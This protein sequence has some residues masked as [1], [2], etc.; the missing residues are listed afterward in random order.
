MRLRVEQLSYRYSDQAVIDD[1]SIHVAAGEFVGVVGPNGSGKSTLLKNLYRALKPDTGKILLDGE[2]YDMLNAKKI[3][4]KIGVV[5]QEHMIPFDF[6]VDEI[7][8]MGRS[9]YKKLFDM[10]TKEDRKIVE[11]A[12]QNVGLT[13]LAKTNY[14]NLSGGERQRVVI[15]RVLAQQTNFLML[16]EPTNHLDIQYQLQMFD[17]IK[18]LK[19]TV[20]SAIHDLNLAALYCDRIYI[21]KEG[22]IYTSGTPEEVLTPQLLSE[23]FGI[24]A[25]III[26]PLT[27]KVNI[28]YLPASIE[29]E[30][31]RV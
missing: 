31:E 24:R 6:N 11:Q 21:M 18:G 9:P 3:A 4:Q 2:D 7:V 12:L 17:L 28:T 16:D 10:D 26:H 8:A 23:V 30:G 20:V 25:H 5:G 22:R 14:L 1:I 27:Q 29:R 19:L 15:A 13:H